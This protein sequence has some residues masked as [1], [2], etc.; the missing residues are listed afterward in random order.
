[1]RVLTELGLVVLDRAGPALEVVDRPARTALERSAAFR[2]YERRLEDGRRYLNS[3]HT[4][5][6]AA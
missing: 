2:A 5:R 6:A 1:V 4:T 3:T